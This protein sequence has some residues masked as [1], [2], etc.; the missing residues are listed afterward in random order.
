MGSAGS[1]V[2]R[3]KSSNSNKSEEAKPTAES[4]ANQSRSSS[5]SLRSDES[6]TVIDNRLIVLSNQ[7]NQ[8]NNHSNQSPREYTSQEL[9][10]MNNEM[11]IL[12]EQRLHEL[13]TLHSQQENNNDDNNNHLEE[14][15]RIQQQSHLL[16]HHY[17]IN[18]NDDDN[19]NDDELLSQASDHHL[20]LND[21]DDDDEEDHE[22][23]ETAAM[24]A[25]ASMSLEMDN[26]DLL[27]NL[28]YFGDGNTSSQSIGNSLNAALEE[29]IAAHSASNTPYKLHPVSDS[30]LTRLNDMIIILN[31]DN[32]NKVLFGASSS[33]AGGSSKCD[34]DECAVCKDSMEIGQPVISLKGC[35]HCFHSQCLLKWMELQDI[36]PIC[37][38]KVDHNSTASG[39]NYSVGIGSDGIGIREDEDDLPEVKKMMK[40][41]N[42]SIR[43]SS[44]GSGS[45]VVDDDYESDYDYKDNNDDDDEMILR[46]KYNITNNTYNSESKSSSND[47]NGSIESSNRN[48]PSTSI[49]SVRSDN[50]GPEYIET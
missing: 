27:F 1:I 49:I 3:K 42:G 44:S 39:S 41:N 32:K 22:A 45:K 43:V 6:N 11:D 34:D 7:S 37:R 24:F 12:I 19:D 40:N 21:D 33:G 36:C 26:D 47:R 17:N 4:V 46:E 25:S 16:T 35:R 50:G 48:S 23:N 13:R 14:L 8:S 31:K 28:L 18:R 20:N 2:S 30:I 38:A 10:D 5:S 29:T 15:Q 9:I